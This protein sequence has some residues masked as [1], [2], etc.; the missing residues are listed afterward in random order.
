MAFDRDM[1]KD[2][3]TKWERYLYSTEMVP[4][5]SQ[6]H[7]IRK[8]AH[9][10]SL[11]FLAPD[12]TTKMADDAGGTLFH[13]RPTGAAG[14]SAATA[15]SSPPVAASAGVD[16]AAAEA[17]TA[18][19]SQTKSGGRKRVF[20]FQKRW[21]HSL[22]IVERVLP[23]AP[24]LAASD[25][26]SDVVVCML[27]DD[28]ASKRETPK[29]WNR[30]N[31]RRG[32]IEN[33]L[34]SKHPEFMLLLKQK[35][36]AEG[37]LAV[38][39]FLQSMRDGR[40]NVRDEITTGLYA[41]L[42]TPAT[43]SE[44]PVKRSMGFPATAYD[45]RNEQIEADARRKRAKLMLATKNELA[46]IPTKPTAAMYPGVLGRQALNRDVGGVNSPSAFQ[47]APSSSIYQEAGSYLPWSLGL[48][49]KVV[50]AGY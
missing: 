7:T 14:S 11:V 15:S 35:R 47:P 8:A 41:H 36:E 44:V 19:G 46:P 21:L 6:N 24:G 13:A 40:C 38:Q 17:D 26:G 10:R 27:C 18:S 29:V 43:P 37:E 5:T 45:P 50:R 16:P 2:E 12:K 42:Q 39:I 25:S 1:T 31:C 20:T 9:S 34:L 28:P 22:P 33:H 4:R 49:N 48:M 3:G 30:L 32:R 23:D